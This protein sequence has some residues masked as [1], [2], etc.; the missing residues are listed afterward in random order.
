MNKDRRKQL[1]E[2]RGRLDTIAEELGTIQGEE[3]DYFDNMPESMQNGAKGES[4]QEAT[5]ALGSAWDCIND[6]IQYC[7]TAEAT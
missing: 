2:L 4:A 5:D 3:Q 7:E 1:A 6:A